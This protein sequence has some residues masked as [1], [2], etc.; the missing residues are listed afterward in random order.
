MSDQ[1]V[2]V[3]AIT[4]LR[5]TPDEIN[6]NVMD[7]EGVALLAKGMQENGELQP[8]V[9]TPRASDDDGYSYTIIDGEHRRRA[10]LLNGAEFVHAFI[11]DE[12]SDDE[13]AI[14]RL[15]LNKNRG[16]INLNIARETIRD[17]V[18]DGYTIPDLTVTGF[19]ESELESMLAN[20]AEQTQQ[21]LGELNTAQPAVADKP[22]VLEIAFTT[23]EQLKYVRK[24]LKQAAGDTKD[25]GI[26]LLH[27][28][29]YESDGGS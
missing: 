10:A 8:I 9:I 6:P 29:G 11:I 22:H 13:I 17:L 25:A 26:G 19:N 16:E 2:Y 1:T 12:C 20:Q 24:C 5:P 7:D 28:L 18:E 4:D 15:S 14:K 27:V 23:A 21:L 3:V